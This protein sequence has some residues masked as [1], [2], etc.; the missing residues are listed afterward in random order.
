[1][2]KA[3]GLLLL[4]GLV[5]LPAAAKEYKVQKTEDIQKTLA[6]A[7]PS[8]SREIMVDNIFGSITVEGYSGKDIMLTIRKTIKARSQAILELA[9]REVKLDITTEGRSI[10]LY[11]DGPFRDQDEDGRQNWRNP[12]Y[13]VHYDFD[14][15]VPQRIDI[16]LKTVTEGDIVVNGVEGDFDVRNVN[17]KVTMTEMTGSGRAHTVNGAVKVVFRRNPNENCSFKTVNGDLDVYFTDNLS[18]DFQLKTFHGDML[19]DFPVKY[20]PLKSAPQGERKS[21]KYVY[22]GNRFVGVQTGRGGPEMTMDTLNG[23][24]LIH[25]R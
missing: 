1:M 16:S 12:G 20:L 21:G 4:A 6:F 2:K 10:D 17:G 19:S 3:I 9:Q 5:S 22:K 14:I 24:I 7:D 13:Q 8:G 25:K 15:K 18:A 23:D 11:V